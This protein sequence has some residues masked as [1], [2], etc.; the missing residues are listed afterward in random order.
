MLNIYLAAPLFCDA[1]RE[2]NER[3]CKRLE[4]F[5]TVYLP[6]RDGSLLPDLLAAGLEPKEAIRVIFNNDLVALRQCD[7]MLAI[8]DGR[9]VDE[10]VAVEM[11]LAYSDGTPVWAL[12]TDFR[13]LVAIGDNPMIE[14]LIHRG[15]H[16]VTSL[17][18]AL[19]RESGSPSVS[20]SSAI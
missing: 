17:L 5:V 12:K 9:T 14:A 18:D 3:L 20:A 13:S 2:F 1:E 6:Q 8:L 16:S 4:S 10:G 19:R 11:A 7:I 15:F